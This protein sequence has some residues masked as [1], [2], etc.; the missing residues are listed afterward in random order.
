M[1]WLV[2]AWDALDGAI[3]ILAASAWALPVLALLCWG[4]GF[5]PPLPAGTLLSA[6][7]AT[8]PENPG[9]GRPALL[10]TIA[11]AAALCG[12]LTMTAIGRA[13]ARG[14]KPASSSQFRTAADSAL[15]R[16]DDHWTLT[17]STA[18]F[19]PVVRVGLFVAAGLR[20]VSIRRILMLDGM[21]A[22]IWAST[23][24][25]AGHL[26]GRLVDNELAGM[27]IG[28]VIGGSVGVVIGMLA[29][30]LQR[31]FRNRSSSS[32][33]PALPGQKARLDRDAPCES[34]R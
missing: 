18:R 29:D 1:D 8:L 26:G 25:A 21:A 4:D 10:V 33:R 11:A 23:Y 20:K 12:D 15:H 14:G 7:S 5:F 13:I 32:H 9:L 16:L 19:I 27:A 31:R 22:I 30:R 34:R 2:T 24:V 3:P 28:I 6:L 17:L